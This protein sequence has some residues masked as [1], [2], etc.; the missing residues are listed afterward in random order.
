[1]LVLMLGKKMK[2]SQTEKDSLFKKTSKYKPR[3]GFLICCS[4]FAS[5]L[6][7]GS[8][9]VFAFSFVMVSPRL[10]STQQNCG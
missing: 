9:V 8:A 10:L 4:A 5:E 7:V 1:M 6:C 3:L 2:N